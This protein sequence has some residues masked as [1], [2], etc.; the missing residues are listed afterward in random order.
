[1]G[2]L[3]PVS[4]LEAEKRGSRFAADVGAASLADLR[5]LSAEDFFGKPSP[6]P[7]WRFPVAVDGYFLPKN[8]VEIYAGR[9]SSRTVPLLVGWNS[10]ESGSQGVLGREEPTRENYP[11]RPH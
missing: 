11:P 4:L 9:R 2:T 3:T 8:P 6:L 7:E 10:E 5:K 1:M